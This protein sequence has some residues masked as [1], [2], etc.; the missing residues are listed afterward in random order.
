VT[1][2]F[3]VFDIGPDRDAEGVPESLE[4]LLGLDPDDPDSSGDGI[5]DGSEDFDEDGLF[6]L[7][8]GA[9]RNRSDRRGQQR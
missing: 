6:E 8:R 9:D 1:W 4:V 5:A 3:S 2:H 7:R